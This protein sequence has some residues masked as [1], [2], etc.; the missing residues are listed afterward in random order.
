MPLNFVCRTVTLEQVLRCSFGLNKTEISILRHLLYQK[1]EEN[2]EEIMKQV[3]KDRTTIQRGVKRLFQKELLKRRQ[4]NLKDGGYV[5]IYS[6]RPKAELK[7]K[8]NKIFHTF[9]EMVGAEIQKW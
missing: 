6:A 4:L 8:N 9:Q 3:K 1:E 7:E 2:I 5:F